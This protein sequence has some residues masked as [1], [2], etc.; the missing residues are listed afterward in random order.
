MQGLDSAERGET[1]ITENRQSRAD[2]EEDHPAAGCAL[3]PAKP[4]CILRR[5]N[6]AETE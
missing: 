3:K 4:R 2:R 1:V 6:F 5:R